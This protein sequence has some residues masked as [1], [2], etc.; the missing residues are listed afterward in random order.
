MRTNHISIVAIAALISFLAPGVAAS[1]SPGTLSLAQAKSLARLAS[2]ELRAAREAVTAARGREF[3]AKSR[4]NPEL[5]YS[6]ER[7]SGA[8]QTNRQQILGVEQ[9]I[10]LGGQRGSRTSAARFRT[11]AAEARL[12]SALAL[13]EFEVARA[14]ALAVAADRRA[15]LARQ[16]AAAFTDAGRVSGQRLAAGDVSV[17]ADRRLRLE[18]ARYGALEAGANLDRRSAR[19]TLSSLVA[20]N[21]D[22]IA[23]IPAILT[24][25][26]PDAIPQVTVAALQSAAL[27]GRSD[28]RAASLDVE[29]FSAE[30]RLASRERTPTPA[31]FGGF[32][33]ESAAGAPESLTGFAAGIALPLPLFD[34]R[35][36]AIQAADAEVRR[37][38]AEREVVRRRI[39]R[40]VLEAF[41]AL[42]A[43]EQQRAVLAP[44]L[45]SQSAGAL[46]SAQVAYSEGEITLVEWLDAVRAYHE[47]ESAYSDLMAEF[48]IRRATLERAVASPLAA[49]LTTEH[50]QSIL[51]RTSQTL[52]PE[53]NR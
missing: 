48:L 30:S 33:R 1:Q 38:T 46:R 23:F 41:D 36:G 31:F 50:Q 16:A 26:M 13:V 24:D 3:Q 40:E 25:S 2:P 9:R 45:G 44:Q 4:T 42:A 32:K 43:V 10:E 7:T 18:A 34:R 39:S 22:S 35:R 29:S 14:Y 15:A 21:A 27:R 28:Y 37:A 11:H 52:R 49:A 17:Y 51:T 8:G 47:A 6:T 5:S 53:N 20:S 19:V 12:E